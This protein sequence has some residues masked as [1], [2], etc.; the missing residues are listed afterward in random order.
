M[1]FA[2]CMQADQF[3][4]S[5]EKPKDML[6]AFGGRTWFHWLDHTL[7]VDKL[8]RELAPSLCRWLCR[9]YLT[10]LAPHSTR[11]CR[12]WNAK[13]HGE[14][15]LW[16]IALVLAYEWHVPDGPNEQ[17]GERVIYE[18]VCYDKEE[19]RKQAEEGKREAALVQREETPDGIPKK[20]EGNEELLVV[21]T[22][23]GVHLRRKEVE[24][25]AATQK[26][27]GTP[28]RQEG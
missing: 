8:G 12:R 18:H 9:Y 19:E 15:R 14:E 5:K 23:D 20:A 13:Y 3:V 1:P 26:D 4:Y 28:K 21:D 16:H 17:G 11:Y 7:P 24:H 10:C 25:E 6:N 27:E 2:P 22:P